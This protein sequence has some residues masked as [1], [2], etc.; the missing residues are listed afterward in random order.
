MAELR[1]HRAE[2]ELCRQRAELRRHKEELRPH[3]AE[4]RTHRA[5]LRRHGAD[6][7]VYK[8]CP[9]DFLT[10]PLG[11]HIVELFVEE[12]FDTWEVK[13]IT[14]EAY[15]IR[16]VVVYNVEQWAHPHEGDS[17]TSS[18]PPPTA[19]ELGLW[20]EELNPFKVDASIQGSKRQP[21]PGLPDEW[22]TP[23]PPVSVLLKYIMEALTVIRDHDL[24]SSVHARNVVKLLGEW[25]ARTFGVVQADGRIVPPSKDAYGWST[26]KDLQA[27]TI[28]WLSVTNTYLDHKWASLLAC[29]LHGEAG[30]SDER[31]AHL[32][33][34][35]NWKAHNMAGYPDDPNVAELSHERAT[36]WSSFKGT[37]FG[38][39]GHTGSDDTGMSGQ[40]L[41]SMGKLTNEL[42]KLATQPKKRWEAIFELLASWIT[43]WFIGEVLGLGEW[44]DFFSIFVEFTYAPAQGCVYASGTERFFSTRA[45][46]MTSVI[47]VEDSDVEVP[48]KTRCYA[49]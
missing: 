18:G 31:F 44:V 35:K 28:E 25:F 47:M 19:A 37:L 30:A 41:R 21:P 6:L 32:F 48:E 38:S 46:T 8:D 24:L 40:P 36:C 33:D 10:K 39:V 2:A 12:D 34:V 26:Y 42:R 13:Q 11:E 4:L 7:R 1:T 3:R 14:H 9:D 17:A 43:H 16:Q 15:N 23:F 22:P 20:P 29:S 49:L 45:P 27:L 5:D